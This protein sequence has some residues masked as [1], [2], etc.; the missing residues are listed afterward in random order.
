ME[1]MAYINHDSPKAGSRY[2]VVGEL[3]FNQKIPLNHTGI[4]NTYNVS[5]LCVVFMLIVFI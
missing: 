5:G 1:G 3:R 4:D 2:D